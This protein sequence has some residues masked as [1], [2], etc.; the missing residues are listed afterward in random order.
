MSNI[1]QQRV[2]AAAFWAFVNLPENADKHFELIDGE[3]IEVAPSSDR[4][5]NIAGKFFRY[6]DEYLDDNPIG[7]VTGADGGYTMYD[8]DIYEPDAAFISKE[9]QPEF[10]GKHS[11]IA[12]DIAVEV[13]SE[14]NTAP[15][16]RKRIKKYLDSGTRMV[17]AVYPDEEIMAVHRQ[18]PDGTETTR[19][20]KIDQVFDGEDVLPGFKLPVRKVFPK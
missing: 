17:I 16:L 8:G 20:L 5:S 18:N 14:S 4:N 9:R 1:D 3:I 6:F 10:V 11:P 12:P 19:T 15:K 2:S 13:I 7:F